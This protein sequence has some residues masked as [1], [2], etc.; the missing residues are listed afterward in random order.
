MGQRGRRQGS[1]AVIEDSITL[2][3][4]KGATDLLYHGHNPSKRVMPTLYYGFFEVYRMV[5]VMDQQICTASLSCCTN[6]SSL[7]RT[8]KILK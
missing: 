3:A 6:I 8:C 5:T 7:M 1:A 2:T 4:S